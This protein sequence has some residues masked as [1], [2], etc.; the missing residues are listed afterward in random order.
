MRVSRFFDPVRAFFPGLYFT[1]LFCL[2]L[3]YVWAAYF[4]WKYMDCKSMLDVS[5]FHCT[6]KAMLS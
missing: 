4:R 6:F 2:I 1:R 3:F 5:V